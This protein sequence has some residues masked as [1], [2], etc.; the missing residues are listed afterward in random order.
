MC[1]RRETHFRNF[2]HRILDTMT[3]K[4][5]GAKKRSEEVNVARISNLAAE[6]VRHWFK[7][8]K[9][10]KPFG[11]KNVARVHRMRRVCVM[12]LK[13]VIYANSL[14]NINTRE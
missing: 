5:F 3:T 4:V 9:S 1:V 11:A 12:A 7:N 2:I 6:R 14:R 8:R 10:T 13:I